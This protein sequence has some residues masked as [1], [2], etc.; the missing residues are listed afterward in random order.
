[1]TIIA[2]DVKFYKAATNNDLAGNGGRISATEIVDDTL[3]NLFPN[4]SSAE[5]VAGLTRY[6]KMFLRNENVEDLILYHTDLWVGTQSVGEDY[7]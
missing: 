7:F 6:R 4:V 3:N 5:R 2:S 1:M